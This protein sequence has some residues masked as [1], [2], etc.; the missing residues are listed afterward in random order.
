MTAKPIIV[1]SGLPRSGTSMLMQMLA[2]GGIPVYCDAQRQADAD[3]P[4]GY[5]ELTRVKELAK[6]QDRA[7]LGMAQGK[8]IKIISH[9][10]QRLPGEYVY[11]TILLKR[12][13]D[14]VLAS[15]NQMLARRGKHTD[16]NV[17][18]KLRDLFDEH[19]RHIKNWLGQQ[20]N[21]EVFEV[22][23]W[24]VLNDPAAHAKQLQ[25]FLGI[26]LQVEKMA[27][28]PDAQLYRQR[29]YKTEVKRR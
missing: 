14:E 21:F 19:R 15:Q 27:A 29:Q 8:A 20:N 28:V 24:R 17:T 1:V 11:K 4:C 2:A 26:G 9:L 23:Y 5:Y 10:L 18:A 7:W 12:D 3:N 13:L 22:E 6:R 25:K 16:K